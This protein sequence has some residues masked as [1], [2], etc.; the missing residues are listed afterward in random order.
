MY[1]AGVPRQLHTAVAVLYDGVT[2][3]VTAVPMFFWAICRVLAPV[4][5]IVPL[6]DN[7]RARDLAHDC[8][9]EVR[10]RCARI[11]V[12]LVL[13][14]DRRTRRARCQDEFGHPCANRVVLIGWQRDGRQDADNR[15]DDHQFDQ[16]KT[17]LN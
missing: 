4:I 11:L 8:D 15:H 14:G 7:G 6:L 5:T 9:R 1:F 3:T 10:A 13:L 12:R 16:G 17:F 2:V